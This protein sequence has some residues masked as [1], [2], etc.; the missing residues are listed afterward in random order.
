MSDSFPIF[1]VPSDAAEAPEA[2]GTKPKFWL[3]HP[4]FG[5]CLFKQARSNTGEDWSEKIA[6]EIAQLLGLP[7]HAKQ[8]LAT[9]REHPGTLSPLIIPAKGSLTHGNDIL[10]GIVSNYPRHETLQCVR[11]HA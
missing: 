9:Y 3:E 8:E 11:T 6:A 5:K 4:E 1:E 2:T 7:H 10:A